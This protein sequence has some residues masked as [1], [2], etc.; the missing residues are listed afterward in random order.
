MGKE[1]TETF[2]KF[3]ET[4][5]GEVSM[6]GIV[7]DVKDE[8]CLILAEMMVDVDKHVAEFEKRRAQEEKKEG[9]Q[10]NA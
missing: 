9:I 1:Q 4:K 6:G 3:V 5:K 8:L 2:R 7:G 10:V